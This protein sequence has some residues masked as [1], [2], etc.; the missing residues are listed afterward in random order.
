MKRLLNLII[1]VFS[2]TAQTELLQ[3]T[4]SGTGIYYNNGNVGIGTNNPTAKLYVVGN[5]HIVGNTYLQ[6]DLQSNEHKLKI[7][8]Q[9]GSLEI[10]TRGNAGSM[11]LYTDQASFGFN[12]SASFFGH[13]TVTDPTNTLRV[14]HLKG[15]ALEFTRD[16]LNY[17]W[18]TKVGSSL[19]L[20]TNGRSYGPKNSN[21]TLNADQSSFF[22]GNVGIGG[23]TAPQHPLVIRGTDP[24]RETNFYG[25]AIEFTRDNA[26]Y[27]WGKNTNSH[28]AFGTGGRSYGLS[29]SNLVLKADQDSYFNGKVGIGTTSPNSKLQVN[30]NISVGYRLDNLNRYIGK[31]E[32]VDSFGGNSNWIGFKS[33]ATE[34]YI[35]FGTHKSGVSGGERMR[36]DATGNV[37]IGTTNTNGAKLAVNGKAQ[38][39]GNYYNDY[40]A[41][42]VS[43]VKTN[44]TGWYRIGSIHGGRG[45]YEVRII[46]RGTNDYNETNLLLT[47]GSYGVGNAI[48]VLQ[49]VKYNSSRVEAVRLSTENANGYLDLKLH[50]DIN[51]LEIYIVKKTF[52]TGH[53]YLTDLEFNPV[54]GSTDAIQAQILGKG[55][56]LQNIS[57]ETHLPGAYF[58]GAIGIGTDSPT[59]H[60]HVK[61]ENGSSYIDL[62]TVTDKNNEIRFKYN[63]APKGYV[64]SRL[65]GTQMAIGGGST[66]N[67]MFIN[68]SDGKVGIGTVDPKS[69]LEI[70][71]GSTVDATGG[72]RLNRM[73][74]SAYHGYMFSTN[75]TI[76][77]SIGQNSEGGFSIYEDGLAAKTR[78]IVKDGGNVGIGT[79]TPESK[80]AVNGTITT[81]KIKIT[82]NIVGGADFVF[83][84]DYDL[85]PLEEVESFIK[86]NKHLPEI[87]SAKDM[88]E[89]GLDMSEFQIK[90][91]QKIEELTLHTIRQEKEMAEMKKAAKK[92]RTTIQLLS[93]ELNALKAAN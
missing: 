56:T 78:F 79:A 45:L 71:T 74:S 64:W 33:T 1:L 54:V 93:S 11:K 73:S 58:S 13:L 89:N 75:N 38:F 50:N 25:D 47:Q 40:K 66:N 24:G 68:T 23:N 20:G 91:L 80:L 83:E 30:G 35:T 12:A 51:K 8:D 42:D 77:W 27:L 53:L 31:P 60:L 82:A 57:S 49:N 86:E 55:H 84:D 2:L 32:G 67:S 41:F 18:G 22:N 6:G 43:T 17:I 15:D 44:G 76:D 87:P 19:A 36:I 69:I 28:L 52:E 65:N 10:G 88:K 90:L 81:K 72:I 48:T 46:S 70:N 5:T 34:D 4:G 61:N 14:A 21:L 62:E 85:K 3:G 37:G 16:N 63:G 9:F 26:N 29:T 92:D 39:S 7:F 59:G